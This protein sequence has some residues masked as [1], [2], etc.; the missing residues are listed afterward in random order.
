MPRKKMDYSNTHFYTIVCKDLDVKDCYVGHTIN[1]KNRRSSHKT[2]CY[3]TN[4]KDYNMPLY[5]FIRNNGGWNN[6]DLVLIET[7]EVKNS[8]ETRKKESMLKIYRL[9]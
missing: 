9:H 4:C 3:N 2:L 8:L 6:F 7:M 5:Q 1:S